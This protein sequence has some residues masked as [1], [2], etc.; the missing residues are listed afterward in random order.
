VL[1]ATGILA[2]LLMIFEIQNMKHDGQQIQ[3]NDDDDDDVIQ[4]PYGMSI[5]AN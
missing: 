5:R 2:L 1:T 4:E 3:I